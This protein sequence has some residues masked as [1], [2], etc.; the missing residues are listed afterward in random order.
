M[1]RTPWYDRE[2]GWDHGCEGQ[3]EPTEAFEQLWWLNYWLCCGIG[4]GRVC[5]PPCEHACY[6]ACCKC[7]CQLAPPGNPV[8]QQVIACCCCRSILMVPPEDMP[9]CV[10]CSKRPCGGEVRLRDPHQALD[11]QDLRWGFW[12]C[13]CGC[14]GMH[15]RIK[16]CELCDDYSTDSRYEVKQLCCRAKCLCH[17]HDEGFHNCF[18]L[19]T[20]LCCWTHYHC[21]RIEKAPCC[22]CFNLGASGTKV[23]TLQ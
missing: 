14:L 20:C 11:A 22:V 23:Q 1:P 17:D 8:C 7:V 5:D 15:C 9:P 21:P 16:G 18:G 4:C 12:P 19:S 10:C 3:L 2:L 6:T 13:W